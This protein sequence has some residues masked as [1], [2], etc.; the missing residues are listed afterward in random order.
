MACD[1]KPGDDIVCV[2]ADEPCTP[3]HQRWA[4]PLEKGAVYQVARLDLSEWSAALLVF[5]AGHPNLW[6]ETGEDV[7]FAASRFR[8]VQRRDLTA[9]L[10]TPNTIEGPVRS[11]KR[12]KA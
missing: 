8:K 1:F 9:W 10:A 5:L 7:G 2:D 11:S 6:I 3:G 12:V 4:H